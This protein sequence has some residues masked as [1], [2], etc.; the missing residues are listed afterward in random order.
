[1][2]RKKLTAPI[3]GLVNAE[4]T[5]AIYEHISRQPPP[6]PHDYAGQATRKW[7]KGMASH[8]RREFARRLKTLRETAKL[9]INAL[10]RA[11]G[12]DDGFLTRLEA[13]ECACGLETVVKI[14]AALGVELG[15][16]VPDAPKR[17]K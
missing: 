11:A 10:A 8:F 3:D 4:A 7:T 16:L 6:A 12:I 5:A 2:A 9:S 14:G 13:A 15:I 17:G 1:M